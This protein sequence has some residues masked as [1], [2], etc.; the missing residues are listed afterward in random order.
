MGTRPKN[1]SMR[2]IFQL[3]SITLFLFLS[4]PLAQSIAEEEGSINP[5]PKTK[6]KSKKIPSYRRGNIR[7]NGKTDLPEAIYNVRYN[8]SGNS[9]QELANDFLSHNRELLKFDPESE[10]ETFEVTSTR[11]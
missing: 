6:S 9:D 2:L 4:F 7:Y 3:K 11:R 5:K 8:A 1:T 10:S